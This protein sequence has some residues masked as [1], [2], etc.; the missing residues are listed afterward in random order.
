MIGSVLAQK[1][2]SVSLSYIAQFYYENGVAKT[3]T[4]TQHT[5]QQIILFNTRIIYQ[6]VL[7][8][9]CKYVM[10]KIVSIQLKK[11]VQDSPRFK[12]GGLTLQ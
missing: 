10:V 7:E 1:Y 11:T 5:F 6:Y 8:L 2:C 9:N 3:L 12:D 4:T